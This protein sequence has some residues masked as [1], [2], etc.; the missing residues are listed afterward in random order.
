MVLDSR[1]N[2]TV[3]AEVYTDSLV[4]SAMV[5]SG[6]STGSHE[7]VELRDGGKDFNGKN[8][9]RA[10]S[11]IK[12]SISPALK[13]FAVDDQ[14]LIDET[15]IG[16]DGS[17]NKKNL[18]ANSILGV[19]MACA[20]LGASIHDL[21][22]HEYLG[23][24]IKNK[25][26]ALPIP[27]ANVIN[28]GEHAGN[29]LL[30]QEFMIAPYKAKS[31]DEA[32]KIIVEI[33]HALKKI[34]AESFGSS[35]TSVGDEGGFAPPISRPEEALD[36]LVVAA[37]KAGHYSKIGFALDPAASE[38]YRA[39]ID[40]YEVFKN[41]F[42]S[43]D[44]FVNYYVSL[45]RDYRI[46]SIE[47][48]FHEDDFEAFAALTKKIGRR[49]QIVGDDLTVSNIERIKVAIQKKLC[50]ALLLKVNQVGSVTEALDAIYLAKEAGWEVMV[51]HR[52]GETEDPFISDLAVGVGCGQIKLGAPARGER[53][54]KYNQL[55]R[56]RDVFPRMRFGRK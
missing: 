39:D 47:D 17:P 15:M 36:L 46:I 28:G 8:V 26:F 24:M 23:K 44:E 19:S 22:L 37:K 13:G 30:F 41:K 12:R 20:R 7:A 52:S 38:F 16:R 54:A 4:A 48:P 53:T 31:F 5:P 11:K 51:S 10:I 34:L 29:D 42:M 9:S 14:F 33:Y 45:A 27:F 43:R 2:P 55:L 50:N 1:G 21:A 32:V 40:K 35:A 56:I 3:E 25:N 49:V 6:A 18:G